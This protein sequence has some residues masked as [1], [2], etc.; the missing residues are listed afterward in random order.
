MWRRLEAERTYVIDRW[1]GQFIWFNA[2]VA[3]QSDY[4]CRIRDNSRVEVVAERALPPEAIAAGVMPDQIVR[5]G[6][7]SPADRRPDHV[8]PPWR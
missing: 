8:P 3:A 5:L 2:I 6:Q 7:S 4:V 1:F